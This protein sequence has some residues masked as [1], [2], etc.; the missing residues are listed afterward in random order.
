MK[1]SFLKKKKVN[2][3]KKLNYTQHNNDNH[4][5]QKKNDTNQTINNQKNEKSLQ[6]KTISIKGLTVNLKVGSE[7][8]TD[9]IDSGSTKNLV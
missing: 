4:N 8:L 9:L 2:S 1:S 7:D 5:T 3:N 6:G